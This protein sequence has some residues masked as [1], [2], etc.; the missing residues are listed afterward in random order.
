MGGTATT[1][2][3][4]PHLRATGLYLAQGPGTLPLPWPL[5]RQGSSR[6]LLHTARTGWPQL[7]P[8]MGGWESTGG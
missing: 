5:C 3:P 4:A 7:L 2:L 8:N 1:S 6:G